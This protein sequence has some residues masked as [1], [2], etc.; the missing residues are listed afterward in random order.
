[1]LK[2]FAGDGMGASTI[3]ASRILN[4]QLAGKSGEETS[5]AMDTLPYTGDAKVK[6]LYLL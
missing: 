3:A 5:L 1:M 4:G 2:L 6:F